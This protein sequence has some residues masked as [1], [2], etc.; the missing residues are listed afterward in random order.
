M[1]LPVSLPRLVVN[2]LT[3]RLPTYL[4]LQDGLFSSRLVY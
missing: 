1:A 4:V 2:A 3:I